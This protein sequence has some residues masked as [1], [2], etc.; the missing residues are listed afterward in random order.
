MSGAEN[1]NDRLTAAE[2]FA[3][4]EANSDNHQNEKPTTAGARTN[5]LFVVVAARI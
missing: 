1:D 4:F 3:C 5:L 2:D